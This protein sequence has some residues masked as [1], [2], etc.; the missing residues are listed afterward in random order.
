M[1]SRDTPT[2][3]LLDPAV[4]PPPAAVDMFGRPRR[5]LPPPWA[6]PPRVVLLSVDPS[7]TA[8]G[9]AVLAGGDGRP[10]DRVA[11]GVW[12]PSRAVGAD[13]AIEQLAA[14]VGRRVGEDALGRVAVEVPDGGE[15]YYRDAGGQQKRL[16]GLRQLTYAQAVGACRAAARVA[17]ATVHPV[18]MATWK[19]SARKEYTALVVANQLGGYRPRHDNEADAR[20]LGLWWHAQRELRGEAGFAAW[21]LER[22]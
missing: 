13:D 5:V 18:S 10:V 16:G 12:H 7:A 3:N 22:R 20:G 6:V 14:F 8:T 1:S 17:G 15:R 4:S 21:M 2:I 19:G 9:W 11:S